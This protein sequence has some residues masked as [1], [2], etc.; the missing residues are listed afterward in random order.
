MK[1]YVLCAACR[2]AST[3][4]GVTVDIIGD[5]ASSGPKQLVDTT[6]DT[7]E[8]AQVEASR[9]MLP[10]THVAFCAGTFAALFS[11]PCKPFFLTAAQEPA[12][13]YSGCKVTVILQ[14]GFVVR[15][16]LTV[17]QDKGHYLL[18]LP[19]GG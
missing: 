7:F 4:A 11:L 3:D 1:T 14:A 18:H 15:L 8:R 12:S 19:A 2:N 5:R 17:V 9:R 16:L 10:C 13:A 6:K